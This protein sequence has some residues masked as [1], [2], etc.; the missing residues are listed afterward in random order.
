M[1]S[2][3]CWLWACLGSLLTSG[4]T[5]FGPRDS[6]LAAYEA[7]RRQL[8]GARGIGEHETYDPTPT[9]LGWKDF[10]PDNLP[11][12]VNRL[13]G[14]GPDPESAKQT[15]AAAEPLYRAAIEARQRNPDAN[16]VKQFTAAA[17]QYRSAADQWPN[18]TL[19]HD[20]LFLLAE[21]HFF[22]DRYPDAEKVFEELLSKY[23]NSKYLDKIQPRRF[24]IA[25]YWLSMDGAD[26]QKFHEFNLI[27]AS[28]PTRD[29]YGQ[30]VRVLDRIRLDDPTG[31][32]A[33]DATM[34]LGNAFFRRSEFLRADE[35]Y[36]DLRKTFPSSEHQFRAHFLGVKAKLL[37]YQGPDYSANAINEAEK[38]VKQILRQ[39]PGDAETE[40]EYLNRAAAEIRYHKAQRE[41][42]LAQ[43]YD[44]R[45]E[46]GAA[47]FY[48][49]ALL[50]EYAGTPF[51]KESAQRMREIGGLPETPEPRLS[52]LVDLFPENNDAP[53]LATDPSRQIR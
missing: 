21:S 43:H 25:Q 46:F 13:A 7:T 49:R 32:L 17:E 33:D 44:R 10:S 16:Y 2:K 22:A 4:C 12:T 52:W 14:N 39:F 20:A 6:T 45:A 11:S 36:S 34:A 5:Y 40:R 47:K 28:L 41:W 50:D 35:Y 42:N 38:L 51:A 29:R 31:K 48:Y 24:S 19:E 9:S 8:N 23:P 3:N 1:Q 18:S 30:A 53:V 37:S 15:Y 26:R 27:D